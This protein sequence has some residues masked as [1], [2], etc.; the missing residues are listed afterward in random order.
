[1]VCVHEQLMPNLPTNIVGFGR[2]D[3]S[4]ILIPRGGI[5]MPI[6]ISWKV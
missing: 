1:M 6:G 3:S 2:F 4:T 5:P